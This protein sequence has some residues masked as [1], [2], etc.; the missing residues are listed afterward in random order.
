MAKTKEALV[1]LS[2]FPCSIIIVGVGG[3]DFSNMEELDGDEGVL[4]DNRGNRAKRDI[5]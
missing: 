1:A 4:R 5:V 3:A 2:A